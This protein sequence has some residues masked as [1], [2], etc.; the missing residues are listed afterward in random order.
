MTL[1][2]SFQLKL[3]WF[4][5]SLR[6]YRLM[7]SFMQNQW[8]N[9]SFTWWSCAQ[10]IHAYMK[11]IIIWLHVHSN[12]IWIGMNLYAKLYSI[13]RIKDW[14]RPLQSSSPTVSPGPAVPQSKKLYGHLLISLACGQTY[15]CTNVIPQ[16]H[17]ETP[18]KDDFKC[19]E[20]LN[21]IQAYP[22]THV[23][24]GLKQQLCFGQ[25]PLHWLKVT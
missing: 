18:S 12:P 21:E 4:H 25:P 10:R 17:F 24:L 23:H 13:H 14:K 16:L 8:S 7:C 20:L 3:L 6:S 11:A 9:V 22:S 5:D 2:G 19:T 1:T 15:L